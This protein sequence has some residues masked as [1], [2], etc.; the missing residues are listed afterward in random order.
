MP[1]L[2]YPTGPGGII[3]MLPGLAHFVVLVGVTQPIDLHSLASTKTV[4]PQ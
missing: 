3:E 1:A 4:L 2:R